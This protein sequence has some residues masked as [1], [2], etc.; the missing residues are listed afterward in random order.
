MGRIIC[1]S[2]GQERNWGARLGQSGATELELPLLAAVACRKSWEAGEILLFGTL[3]LLLRH[4]C[5]CSPFWRAFCTYIYVH[6]HTHTSPW[7]HAP[8]CISSARKKTDK[9]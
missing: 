1:K 4:S 5:L 3:D 8:Q 6:T 7:V 9:R 2:I